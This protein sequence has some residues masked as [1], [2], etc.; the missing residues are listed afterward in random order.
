MADSDWTSDFLGDAPKVKLGTAETGP[1]AVLAQ[2]QGPGWAAYARHKVGMVGEALGSG[3]AGIAGMP[4][5][6]DALVGQGA[7]KLLG[8]P[9][10]N[11]PKQ[12][13]PL[14]TS[15]GI[16]NALG[17]GSYAP[18]TSADSPAWNTAMAGLE[19]LPSA[20]LGMATGMEPAAAI[21]AALGSGV[22]GKLGGD[23]AGMPGQVAGSIL[24]GGLG[25]IAKTAADIPHTS[26]VPG[27]ISAL[28]ANSK[29]FQ[30]A[31]G[32]LK[33]AAQ[34]LADQYSR[35]SQAEFLLGG[36]SPAPGSQ[37]LAAVT[38]PEIEARKWQALDEAVP[39]GAASTE[40][41]MTAAQEAMGD[42]GR[43]S[44]AIN[45]KRQ[46]YKN[47]HDAVSE[48]APEE[49]LD[50][51]LEGEPKRQSF[52]STWEDLRAGRSHM[53][54]LLRK[55]P[56]DPGMNSIYGGFNDALGDIVSNTEHPEAQTRWQD[57]NA[58]T[59]DAMAYHQKVLDPLLNPRSAPPG[60]I[61][62]RLMLGATKDSAPLEGILSQMPGVG[63]ELLS[64]TLNENPQL[65]TRLNR[66]SQEALAPDPGFRSR[67][68]DAV[69]ADE[70]AAK[71]AKPQSPTAHGVAGLKGA[72]AADAL[73]KIASPLTHA[74]VPSSLMPVVQ[75]AA[76]FAG[77]AGKNPLDAV[78][79]PMNRGAI[80]GGANAL[81]QNE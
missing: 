1:S 11:A 9:P 47:I 78:R 27:I 32:E 6:L 24:G 2:D 15:S 12:V 10:A 54:D 40:P 75:G 44:G 3:L 66:Q 34:A 58:S 25:G 21:R 29:N 31:G 36:R 53:G 22:L 77:L 23:V 61:A 57:A 14:P 67:I 33:S 69:Q 16:K 51:A 39:G 65:W 18:A 5:D 59:Q 80:L 19:A 41:I 70:D 28:G 38:L 68:T 20:G 60:A 35:N 76:E 37:H 81:G 26:Q 13:L 62:A 50:S 55:N 72:E 74:L 71:A 43:V 79:A 30:D 56:N 4:G 17:L 49:D 45:P 73:L 7:Q 52:L 42:Q 46:F 64:A 63:N 48:P 8:P